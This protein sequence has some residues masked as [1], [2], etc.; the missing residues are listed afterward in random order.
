MVGR[1][2]KQKAAALRALRNARAK[3][4]NNG[5]QK[6]KRNS[7]RVGV[8]VVDYADVRNRLVHRIGYLDKHEICA[9]LGCTYPC[10]WEWQRDGKFPLA[11]VVGGKSKWPA[12]V[13]ADW[14]DGLPVRPVKAADASPDQ[15]IKETELA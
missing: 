10:I 15:K 1:L 4:A 8:V 11:R 7:R 9:L 12:D 3:A 13:V 2:R 5:K 14:L 6:R